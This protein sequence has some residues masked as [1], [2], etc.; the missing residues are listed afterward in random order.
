MDFLKY[1]SGINCK[2]WLAGCH[3]NIVVL[4]FFKSGS[5]YCMNLFLSS[6]MFQLKRH[7][8]THPQS[9]PCDHFSKVTPCSPKL[10]LIWG[11][12]PLLLLPGRLCIL[13]WTLEQRTHSTDC[14]WP[15]SFL[16]RAN[17]WLCMAIC[18]ACWLENMRSCIWKLVWLQLCNKATELLKEERFSGFLGWFCRW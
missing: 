4:F 8:H 16:C 6:F 18:A 10:G 2:P 11:G 5:F 12:P 17:L 3:V 13:L 15:Y 9:C 1:M 7:V 14:V